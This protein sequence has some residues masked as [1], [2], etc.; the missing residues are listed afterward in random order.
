MAMDVFKAYDI[1]GVYGKGIDKELAWKV[2]RAFARHLGGTRYIAGY[3]ARLHSE[4][5]YREVMRGLADE[6]KSVRG[7]GLAST[8]SLHYTQINGKYDGA[9]MVT[10]SH[11]PPEYHGFKLFGPDGG[12]VSGD[13]GLLDVKELLSKVAGEAAVPGGSITKDTSMEEYLE[14][15]LDY[16]GERISGLSIVVDASH[17]S[18]G[19]ILVE[20]FSRMGIDATVINA[21]PDG[22]FPSHGP[23]PL[24][25]KSRE[26]ICR[27][28][29]E[30]GADAGA[31]L[32]GDG[33][34]VLFV[35]EKGNAIQNYFLSALI[36]E[37]LLA[38]NPGASI[39]YDLISSRVLPERIGE[40]GGT[41]VVSRVGYTNLYDR[42]VET[43]AVFGTET[44]GH[45][46]FK[47]S[48]KFYTESAARAIL[49]L[50]SILMKKKEP[51]SRLVAPL[52]L[53]YYQ[54]DELNS[55]V[56]DKKAAMKRIDDSFAGARK[57]RLDGLSVDAGDFWFNVRPSNTEPL[58]RLRLEAKDRETGDRELLRL[59]KLIEE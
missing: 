42:M 37:E 20:L 3:D 27:A 35:D 44:S 46:Y 33:D 14:F 41:P 53:R 11:N 45:V 21:E 9:V 24:E 47:V 4:E 10:A 52:S 18:A 54:A 25:V 30:K 17:G 36:A 28:V 50:L 56:D 22:T 15:L 31:I 40:L 57:D 39:V 55:E 8:P 5:L 2:G 13:K 32:D 49:L 59:R 23:N 51:L 19:P 1:R 26:V 7:L 58:L 6:G 16:R 43:G 29:K 34:R 38:E 48:D 12:S